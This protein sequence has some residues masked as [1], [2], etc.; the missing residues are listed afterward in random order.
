[1]DGHKKRTERKTLLT[2]YLLYKMHLLTIFICVML[3]NSHSSPI[4]YVFIYQFFINKKSCLK[5]LTK[6]PNI[7]QVI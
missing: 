2:A 3:F 7:T 4:T 6:L 1:M 5:L